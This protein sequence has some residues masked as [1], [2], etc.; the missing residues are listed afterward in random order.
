LKASWHVS[1]GDDVLDGKV[2]LLAVLYGDG[3]A[4]GGSRMVRW[5]VVL[6]GEKTQ[7]REEG[8]EVKRRG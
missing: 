5:A 7:N 8:N 6:G 3:V 2:V 4:P 1:L